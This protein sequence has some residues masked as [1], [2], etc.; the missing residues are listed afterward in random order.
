MRSTSRPRSAGRRRGRPAT[1]R[2]VARDRVS[3]Q[4]PLRHFGLC[5]LEAGRVTDLL[6]PR[7]VLLVTGFAL[8]WLA[9]RRSVRVR[10][11]VQEAVLAE[12]LLGAVDRRAVRRT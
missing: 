8:V 6:L 5:R 12:R 10:V 7:G 2:R 3:L 9:G 1:A 4:A 11:R